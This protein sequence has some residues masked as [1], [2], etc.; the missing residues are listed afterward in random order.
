MTQKIIF[1]DVD[2]TLVDH[3]T[4]KISDKTHTVLKKLQ[5]NGHLIVVATGR[6]LSAVPKLDDIE[7][8]AY[9]T[10]TGSYCCTK[11]EVIFKN[12][13]PQKDILQLKKNVL[14]LPTAMSIAT[15][16]VIRANKHHDDLYEY[17][18]FAS[19]DYIIEDNFKALLEDDVYQAM[20]PVT[21]DNH[22]KLLKD[23]TDI[24]LTGWWPKAIDVVPK[25]GG[26]AIGVKKILNHFKM[27]EKDAIAFGDGNNDIDMFKA[28]GHSVAMGNASQDLK[29]VADAITKS[30]EYDGIYHYCK[31]IGLI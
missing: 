22:H 6:P 10:F 13:I 24:K 12:P 5:D 2:G 20:I 1:L 4:K 8:D 11:D 27:D 31:E 25:T 23:T 21:K 14:D 15:L 28:V 9:L 26:K 17:L 3:N 7:F 29:N 18:G 30:V 16:D 19:I